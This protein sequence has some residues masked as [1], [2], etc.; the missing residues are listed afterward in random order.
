LTVIRLHGSDREA[1]EK[2]VGDDWSQIVAPKD[3]DIKE[4]ARMLEDLKIRNV[5]HY[6]LVN[7]HF[8]GSAPRTIARIGETLHRS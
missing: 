5:S 4:L 2:Q 1:I 7:N 3:Q 8:E 6:L